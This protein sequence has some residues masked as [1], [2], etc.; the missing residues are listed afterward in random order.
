MILVKTNR[1]N[2][3][4]LTVTFSEFRLSF[5]EQGI[6]EADDSY[7]EAIEGMSEQPYFLEIVEEEAPE[8]EAPTEEAPA[9]VKL[10]SLTVAELI[11]LAKERGTKYLNAKKKNLSKSNI[12]KNLEA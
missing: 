1:K 8:E 6:A 10:D 2:R 3:I 11:E 7:R 9:E 4:G 5:N 12:I